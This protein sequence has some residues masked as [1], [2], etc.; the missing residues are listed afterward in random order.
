MIVM[1]VATVRVKA[2]AGL[3]RERRPFPFV[4]AACALRRS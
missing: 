3:A 2:A 1:P 4:F